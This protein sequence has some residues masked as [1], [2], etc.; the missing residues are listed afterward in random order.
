MNEQIYLV[1]D[2]IVE[3]IE[4]PEEETIDISVS[5][6]ARTF[7]ANGIL[8]HNSGF[9]STDLS[10]TNIS[11]SA[12]L[13]HTVDAM[14]GIIQ[15]ELMH[16]NREY[17]LKLLANRDDGYKNSRKKFLINYDLMRITEDPDSPI[18]ND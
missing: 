7:I 17:M 16:S 8:T 6:T 5:G 9:G 4:L 3:I 18:H 14:F 13:G 10:I 15:D 1:E 11:E 12:A 2:E